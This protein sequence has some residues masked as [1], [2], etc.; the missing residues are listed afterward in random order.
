MLKMKTNAEKI[1][2][3]LI[4]TTF[5]KQ[6]NDMY[7][8]GG[9]YDLFEQWLGA[10]YIFSKVQAYR[11]LD[12]NNEIFLNELNVYDFF[13]YI[14][15]MP[16]FIV[17][18]IVNKFFYSETNL[19]KNN[20]DTYFPSEDAQTFFTIHLVLL[21]YSYFCIV[22]IY[23]KLRNLTS[24]NFS[25]LFIF[26]LFLIPSFGG[27]ML[28][29]IKDIPFLL[30]LFLAKLFI[31]DYFHNKNIDQIKGKTLLK[32]SFV[33]SLSLLT[34]INSILFIGFLFFYLLFH[35][36]DNLKIYIRKTTAVVLL[37][38]VF[39]IIGSP[40]SWRN[41]ADWL[42]QSFLFQSNHPWT[43]NTLTNGSYVFAQEMTGSYLATWYFYKMPLFV[44]ICFLLFVFLL[45][46]KYKKNAI[47][48]YSFIFIITNF[49]LFPV[50]KPTAYDGLRHFLFL[51]PFF[52]IV[53]S[54][55]L[56]HV[57][58]I[59]KKIFN[60]III[61]IFTYGLYTQ[62]GLDQYRYTYFNEFTNLE[63]ITKECNNID[64]CGNWTTDYWGFS[65]KEL[66]NKLN[67]KYKD[68]DLLICEPKHVF[69]NYTDVE[70]FNL[71]EFKDVVDLP[72]FYTMSLHRPRLGN[73]SC[74]FYI[75]NFDIDCTTEDVV[76]RKLR[77]YEII[78]S[79]I[80]KC[81]A[82]I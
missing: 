14:F 44:H 62:A 25:L 22:L 3:L 73:D 16:A 58:G 19:P 60:S 34:R 37:A 6:F 32:I 15:M 59:N 82:D 71:I 72:S 78:F 47:E 70:Y 27:H 52:A 67:N 12:F 8:G 38:F 45:K 20:I 81:S 24:N 65:G 79:Y 69:V 2:L 4:I 68:S 1:F 26:I 23:M 56:I 21:I 55:V 48:I 13:G 51:I 31:F 10:G 42:L 36:L 49:A 64:G 29:N 33:I 53:C 18:R 77:G 40:S 66:S 54:S 46:N 50:F 63:S 76:S 75:A 28:F 17:E 11:N 57:R 39:L 30:N 61:L 5:T 74:E 7:K 35:N 80:K 43:G 9:T 41:P